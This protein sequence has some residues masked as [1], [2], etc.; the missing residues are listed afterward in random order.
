MS[1]LGIIIN[2]DFKN[3][4]WIQEMTDKNWLEKNIRQSFAAIKQYNITTLHAGWC[5]QNTFTMNLYND[6]GIK[7]DLFCLA[8]NA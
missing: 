7:M 2:G 6:L 8:W 5:F 3:G 4:S 1:L